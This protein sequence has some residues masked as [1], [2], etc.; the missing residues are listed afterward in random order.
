MR[1]GSL[2]E[3]PWG[4]G[5]MVRAW[6]HR[7]LG[8]G[9]A[10]EGALRL[11]G[12]LQLAQPGPPALPLTGHTALGRFQALHPFLTREVEGTEAIPQ[13]CCECGGR[14]LEG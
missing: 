2:E 9:L 12:G 5:E 8:L 13:S 4:A 6:L 7:A 11:A 10:G 3:E 14:G 1:A